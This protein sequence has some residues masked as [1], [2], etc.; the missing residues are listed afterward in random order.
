VTAPAPLH[1]LQLLL[2]HQQEQRDQAAARLRQAETHAQRAR[3][4][5]ERLLAY[6]SDY[7]ARW[8]GQFRQRA[9]IEIVLCYRSF[10]Q[11]IDQAL[12]QQARAV[13][14]AQA[15]CGQARAVLVGHEQRCAAV[16][17]LLDRRG[18]ELRRQALHREQKQGDELAQRMHRAAR[19]RDLPV[20]S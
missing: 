10:M 6:R 2:R 4:Q 18:A 11:R 1:G 19:A 13:E 12:A 5:A 8:S 9:S 7:E 15:R 16:G 17:R 3:E 14:A 20:P